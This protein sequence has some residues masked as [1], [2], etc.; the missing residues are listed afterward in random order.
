VRRGIIARVMMPLS[1]SAAVSAAE[2]GV[3]A[4]EGIADAIYSVAAW[5]REEHLIPA[6]ATTRRWMRS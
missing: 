4:A 6:D 2:F 3:R 1:C 5:L